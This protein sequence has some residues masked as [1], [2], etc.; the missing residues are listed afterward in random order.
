MLKH[1]VAKRVQK[2]FTLIELMIVVAIVG[3]LAAIAVPAYQDYTVRA[4]VTEGLAL[5][6]QTKTLVAENAIAGQDRLS[7]GISD[8]F[9]T[10][11]VSKL[12]VDDATGEIV[13]TFD[14]KLVPDTKNQLVLTP[15]SE[16]RNLKAGSIPAAAIQ[17]VCAASG[18]TQPDSGVTQKKSPSLDAKYAPA[19]CR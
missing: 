6:A 8:F 9:P 16:G 2:G 17:W 5:A 15:Y 19:E 10:K 11:N 13:I 4:K 14:P 7:K 18:K 3:I 1:R 12:D